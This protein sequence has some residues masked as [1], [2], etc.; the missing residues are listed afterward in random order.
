MSYAK[1]SSA[2]GVLLLLM[3]LFVPSSKLVGFLRVTP[4]DHIAPLLLGATLFK[5]GL[6]IFGLLVITL[7][8]GTIFVCRSDTPAP[9]QSTASTEL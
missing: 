4:V 3:G 7:G 2:I 8:G 6:V 9:L 5:I 1:L